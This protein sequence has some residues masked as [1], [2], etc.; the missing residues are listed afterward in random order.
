MAQTGAVQLLERRLLMS[1]LASIRAGDVDSSFGSGGRIVVDFGSG[2]ESAEALAVQPDGKVVVAG[3]ADGS[4]AVA[5]YNADGSPDVVFGSGGSVRTGAATSSGGSSAMAIGA[6]GGIVVAGTAVATGGAAP[7]GASLAVVVVRYRPDGTPDGSFGVNGTATI[8]VSSWNDLPTDVLVQPDGKVLVAGYSTALELTKPQGGYFL[9]RL[10]ADGSRDEGF[11]GGLVFGAV[12]HMTISRPEGL[13]LQADGRVVLGVYASGDEP[14]PYTNFATVVR[15]DANGA[16][17]GSFAAAPVPRVTP[18]GVAVGADGRVLLAGT[19]VDAD[20]GDFD[21]SMRRYQPNGGADEQFG[22]GGGTL[23]NFARGRSASDSGRVVDSDDTARASAVAPGGSI[24]V[25]SDVILGRDG[26]Q[27]GLARYAPDGSLDRGFGDGGR[28]LDRFG[29]SPSPVDVAVGPDGDVL[30]LARVG[31]TDWAYQVSRYH[32]RA[33]PRFA[34]LSN[35]TLRV[36]GTDGPDRITLGYSSAP[37]TSGVTFVD[38]TMNGVT[39]QYDPVK[40]SRISVRAGKGDDVVDAFLAQFYGSDVHAAFSVT[41]DGGPGN[42]EITASQYRS[43]LIGGAGDDIFMS[44]NFSNLARGDL[45][46]GGPGSDHATI[47]GAMGPGYRG[48]ITRGV[49][50]VA[51]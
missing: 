8:D 9:L 22:A 1:R 48:D 5:R 27:V 7:G 49:E 40:D 43:R 24:V 14:D 25:L 51:F 45:I 6:E 11:G 32:G 30:V 4:L 50:T 20:D 15:Y 42:D 29:T 39:Q 33:V 16:L 21:L 26:E 35:G 47:D 28:V 10:G 46:L 23:T 44:Q 41:L 34:T 12:P 19:G 38:V 31:V 2:S 3:S 13:A 18:V 36:H 17:D 37:T